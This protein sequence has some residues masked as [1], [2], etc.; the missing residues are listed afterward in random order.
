[1]SKIWNARL[2]SYKSNLKSK[3]ILIRQANNEIKRKILKQAKELN[4]KFGTCMANCVA[5]AFL[6][7]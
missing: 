5:A 3:P 1:M 6:P 4:H 7:F 2:Q